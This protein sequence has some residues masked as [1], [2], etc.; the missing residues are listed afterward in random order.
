MAFVEKSENAGKRVVVFKYAALYS[1]GRWPVLALLAASFVT[2]MPIL[3]WI[4]I[5]ALGILVLVN[6][7]LW[8]ATAEVKRAMK[9]G[10]VDGYGSK[11]SFSDP[12]RFEWEIQPSEAEGDK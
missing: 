1:I 11:Y 10:R 4:G 9:K 2:K 12:L 5:G 8:P 3:Q 6:L 7:A